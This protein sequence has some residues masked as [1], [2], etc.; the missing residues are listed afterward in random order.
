MLFH[1]KEVWSSTYIYS[2]GTKDTHEPHTI[3]WVYKLYKGGD[4]KWYIEDH[5]ED[6]GL[7]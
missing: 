4:D 3:K 7:W 5:Y 1:V 2:D 6:F